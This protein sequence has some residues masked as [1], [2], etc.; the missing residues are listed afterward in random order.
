[1]CFGL[2]LTVPAVHVDLLNLLKFKE[3]KTHTVLVISR[4]EMILCFSLISEKIS[5][6]ENFERIPGYLQ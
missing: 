2:K 3:S 4:E 6:V 5:F 1:M